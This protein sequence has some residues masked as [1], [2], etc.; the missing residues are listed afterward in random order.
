MEWVFEKVTGRLHLGIGVSD[1][2]YIST[3]FGTDLENKP[4]RWVPGNTLDFD[5]VK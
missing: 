2:T 4:F 3:N 1:E 5:A